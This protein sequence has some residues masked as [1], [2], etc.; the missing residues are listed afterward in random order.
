MGKSVAIITARGGSKR[1]PRKNI[2]GFCGKPII[3]YSIQAALAADVFEEVMVSTDDEEI[4][5]VARSFGARV[6]FMRSEQTAND[7]AT[8][9]DVIQEVLL[10][11]KQKNKRF[12]SFCALYPT[13]PLLNYIHLKNAKTI[14]DNGNADT[15][16]TIAKFSFPPQRAFVQENGFV[17]YKWE[18]N[19]DKRSQE[20]E[21]LYQDAGQFYFGLTDSFEREKKLIMQRCVPIILNELEVQDI[22]NEADWRLAELK[23]QMMIEKGENQNV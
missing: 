17:R 21:E 10:S 9:A 14:I 22:D 19:R 8:T 15:V 16:V 1:I 18:E 6:P 3:A 11:Y 2:K 20:L 5:E 23:Y 7:F 12:D 4:A 13:A